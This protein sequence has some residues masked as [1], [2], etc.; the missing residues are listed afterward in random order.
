[1][2][3]LDKETF[4][5]SLVLGIFFILY[6]LFYYQWTEEVWDISMGQQPYSLNPYLTEAIFL[7]GVGIFILVVGLIVSVRKREG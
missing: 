2:K 5:V 7:F 1:M 3:N 4:A 6:G